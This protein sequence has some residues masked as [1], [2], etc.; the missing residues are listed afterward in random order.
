MTSLGHGRLGL[1]LGQAG[2]RE[3]ADIREL[4]AVA[5]SFH[6]QRV[7]L[8]DIEGFMRGR[9]AGEVANILRDEL[10]LQGVPVEAVIECLDE[11]DAARGLLTWAHDGDVLVLPTHGA[12]ARQAVVELLDRLQLVNWHAGMPL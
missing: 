4:A 1:L 8:K 2:N 12:A 6:P 10:V 7:V 3:D 5:A 9:V 11:L